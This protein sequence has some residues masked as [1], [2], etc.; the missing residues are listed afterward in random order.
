MGSELCFIVGI[1]VGTPYLTILWGH[2]TIL[3]GHLT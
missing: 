3:W 2:L 1:I